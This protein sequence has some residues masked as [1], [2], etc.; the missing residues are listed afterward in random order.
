MTSGRRRE[1]SELD[2]RT[3]GRAHP[4]QDGRSRRTARLVVARPIMGRR[5][6]TS[7]DFATW[8]CGPLV[9]P[10]FLLLCLRAMRSQIYSVRLAMGVRTQQV[11]LHAGLANPQC[12]LSVDASRRDC[13]ASMR[14]EDARQAD[15]CRQLGRRSISSRSAVR[16]SSPLPSPASSTSRRRCMKPID[17]RPSRTEI[18]ASLVD[19]GGYRVCKWGRSP[20][21]RP[22][23]TR[24]GLDTVELFAFIEETQAGVGAAGRGPRRRRGAR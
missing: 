18:A 22:T 15:A 11:D 5:C 3:L 17:E 10:R 13:V 12:R 14:V 8:T 2:S 19:A 24:L 7:Q 4:A 16:P 1:I 9:R 20:S 6:A 23:S 21:G